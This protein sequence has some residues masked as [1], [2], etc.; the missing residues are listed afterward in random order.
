[1]RPAVAAVI[2]LFVL[3]SAFAI[4][5][6]DN[7]NNVTD[8]VLGATDITVSGMV[9][10]GYDPGGSTELPGD[11]RVQIMRETA[12][13]REEVVRGD[14]VNGMYSVVIPGADIGDAYEIRFT[15]TSS[16]E[17]GFLPLSRDVVLVKDTDGRYMFTV[18]GTGNI[19]VDAVMVHAIGTIA[20]T[21]RNNGDPVGGVSIQVTDQN[22]KVVGG[23]RT[24]GSGYYS[25]ECP[26]GDSYTVS[27]NAPY[28][29]NQSYGVNLGVGDKITQDFDVEVVET[30]TYLFGLDFTHSLMLV[31]GI[32]GL[33][34]F[35]FVISYRI[36]IGK[37]PESSKI[38]SDAKK[39]DQD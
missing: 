10:S 14:V 9:V 13:A 19:T 21:V 6:G 1:M 25:I 34:L 20:G 2:A 32:I 15:S 33:F 4:P 26:V 5:F 22:G 3:V 18:T 37:H 38:H 31:G 11:V 16:G 28:F 30:A 39:K 36:H 12:T 23:G 27:V 35:I 7:S 17:Y 24:D 8:P 29:K